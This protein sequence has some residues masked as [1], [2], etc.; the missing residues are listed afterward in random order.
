MDGA[1][2]QYSN[3]FSIMLPAIS[4]LG[5]FDRMDVDTRSVLSPWSFS[6]DGT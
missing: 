6:P 1:I 5:F 4:S 2:S 3:A